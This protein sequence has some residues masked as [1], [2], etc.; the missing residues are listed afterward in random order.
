MGGDYV[1]RPREL[2]DHV[3]IEC[4]YKSVLN[5]SLLCPKMGVMLQREL[6]SFAG[7]PSPKLSQGPRH[8]ICSTTPGLFW[9]QQGSDPVRAR[10][11]VPLAFFGEE[12]SG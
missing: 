9:G 1:Y 8:F 7:S 12:K 6:V 3:P 11:V 10:F 4:C 2:F 5:M